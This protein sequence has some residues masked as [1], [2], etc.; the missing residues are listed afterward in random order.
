MIHTMSCNLR[1]NSGE[2]LLE[3]V[4]GSGT[5][6]QSAMGPLLPDLGQSVYLTGQSQNV[7]LH[8]LLLQQKAN[9]MT[10]L[11]SVIIWISCYKSRGTLKSVGVS[12]FDHFCWIFPGRGQEERV[13]TQ[14]TF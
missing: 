11:S 7:I 4:G 14:Y 5:S 2:H 6:R 1:E 10:K 8:L 3:L 9:P 12:Y 13:T